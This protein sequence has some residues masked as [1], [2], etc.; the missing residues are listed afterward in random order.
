MEGAREGES[1]YTQ[2]TTAGEKVTQ[3]A[4]IFAY[5]PSWPQFQIDLGTRLSLLQHSWLRKVPVLIMW[6]SGDRKD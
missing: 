6:Q 2:T 3:F 1:L 5:Y 4:N